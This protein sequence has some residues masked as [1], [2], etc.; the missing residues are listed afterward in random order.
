MCVKYQVVQEKMKIVLDTESVMVLQ[1][2]VLAT[3]DGQD[4]VVIYQTALARQIV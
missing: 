1:S 2:Y 4:L 3:K